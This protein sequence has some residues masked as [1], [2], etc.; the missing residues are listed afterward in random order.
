MVKG[1]E[2]SKTPHIS[3]IFS[4]DSS[5]V[6]ATTQIHA[7][8]PV[9]KKATPVATTLPIPKTM[10]AGIATPVAAQYITHPLCLIEANR[11][12]NTKHA[13]ITERNDV[14]KAMLCTIACQLIVEAMPASAPGG[15]PRPGSVEKMPAAI[16]PTPK[17]PTSNGPQ[18][19][20]PTATH[21]E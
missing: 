16:M 11:R 21:R 17:A 13:A 8:H 5:R 15:N 12:T 14:K 1:T 4:V 7:S 19:P 18:V 9:M 6:I 20:P 3:W 10:N 2:V